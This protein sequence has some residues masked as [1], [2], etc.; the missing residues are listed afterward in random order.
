MNRLLILP[1]NC[2]NEQCNGTNALFALCTLY[3]VVAQHTLEEILKFPSD[4]ASRAPL[5]DAPCGTSPD[6]IPTIAG[7]SPPHTGIAA[8]G[9]D[10]A[11]L[12]IGD[13]R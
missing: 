11:G 3:L 2:I 1:T 12:R 4:Q 6:S 5:L 10:V 8:S 9:I 13:Q 7:L